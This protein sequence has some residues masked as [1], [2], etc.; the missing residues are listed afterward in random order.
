MPTLR[1]RLPLPRSRRGGPVGPRDPNQLPE[2]K[3]VDAQIVSHNSDFM[4][5]TSNG[6]IVALL[7]L[8][9]GWRLLDDTG[10]DLAKPLLDLGSKSPAP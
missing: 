3:L 4:A 7:R 2:I 5:L 1:M 6:K 10:T 9:P 8:P